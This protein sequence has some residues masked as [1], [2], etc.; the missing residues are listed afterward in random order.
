NIVSA[1][2]SFIIPYYL[3]KFTGAGMVN[4]LSGKFKAVKKID[5]FAGTNEVKLTAIFK[6]AG[7][8][9]GDVSSLLFGAMNIS[10][11]NFMLG[12]TIGNIPLVIAYSIFGYVLKNVGEKPWVVAIPIV[13]IVLFLLIASLLTTKMIKDNKKDAEKEETLN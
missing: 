6:F 1:V 3:G 12:A 8:L 9:P 13:I 5:E 7:I 10:F 4:T 2:L 11:K